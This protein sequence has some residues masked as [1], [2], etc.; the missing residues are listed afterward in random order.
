MIADNS[1]HLHVEIR[2]SPSV[3]QTLDQY[4]VMTSYWSHCMEAFR[5]G[6]F[7]SLSQSSCQV[8]C[9]KVIIASLFCVSVYLD[10]G[11]SKPPFPGWYKITGV[12]S[13]QNL[14]LFCIIVILSATF[15]SVFIP[16]TQKHRLQVFNGSFA[17]GK[18]LL[19]VLYILCNVC[20]HWNVQWYKLLKD[21]D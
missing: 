11:K 16:S 7:L 20:H 18:D 10:E 13:S 21:A 9:V 1:R 17:L 3:G 5:H 15:M 6:P 2:L 4:S 8:Q 19:N 14:K 12:F